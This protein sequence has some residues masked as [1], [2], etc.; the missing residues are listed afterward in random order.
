MTS[1]VVR[2]HVNLAAKLA[3]RESR[4]KAMVANHM[5]LQSWLLGG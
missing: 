1:K 2:T 4:E 3:R 5:V